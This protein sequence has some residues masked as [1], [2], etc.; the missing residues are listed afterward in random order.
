MNVSFSRAFV[1]MPTIVASRFLRRH[2]VMTALG[3]ES[4]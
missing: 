2:L 4:S 1:E 3:G